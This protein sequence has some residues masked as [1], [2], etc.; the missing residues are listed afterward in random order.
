MSL[1]AMQ[2]EHEADKTTSMMINSA[3]DRTCVLTGQIVTALIEIFSDL[4]VFPERMRQNL[5]L[6]GGLI[7]SERIMLELGRE[8]GRQKAHDVVYEAAQR[9]VNEGRSFTDTLQEEPDVTER[10]TTD[11]ISELLDPEQYTGLCSYFAQEYS[12][13]AEQ[14]GIEL[15]SGGRS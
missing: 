5:E 13:K 15:L 12:K 1:E 6:S 4:K 7:L 10:L 9:S 8:M 14:T 3:I 11:A 2:T